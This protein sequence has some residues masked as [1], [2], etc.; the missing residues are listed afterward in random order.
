MGTRGRFRPELRS[1][2][3]STLA[4][5]RTRVKGGPVDGESQFDEGARGE[6]V[7]EIH[8]GVAR[9]MF[10]GDS[11]KLHPDFSR[12]RAKA[13]VGGPEF[14]PHRASALVGGPKFFE[15]VKAYAL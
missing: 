7:P 1:N 11:P 10:R 13:L 12:H 2:P 4:T 9:R 14:S 8:G 6:N 5:S 15:T 3:N